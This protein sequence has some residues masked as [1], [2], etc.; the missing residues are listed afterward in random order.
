MIASA[1]AYPLDWPDGWPRAKRT[2]A[3]PFRMKRKDFRRIRDG[4][5]HHIELMRGCAV[6]LSTNVP[7]NTFG[8]PY[9]TKGANPE[10]AGVALYWFDVR[11]QQRRAMACDRWTTIVHNMRSL[12]LSL[13][14]IRGIGRWGSSEIVAR[15]FSG[16][17][18][19]PAAGHD[20][21]SVFGMGAGHHPIEA[22]K[23]RYR[24]LARA[25]HPDHGGNPHEMQRLT[26][27]MTSAR[28]E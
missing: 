20:W 9:A 1:E 7:I 18:A 16:F 21:R 6:V 24:E 26:E 23:G 5:L 8:L 19:L 10:D 17:A 15:A 14:A 4:L 22:V 12:E 11:Q 25:A 13:E 27:A 3:G 2:V 28:K